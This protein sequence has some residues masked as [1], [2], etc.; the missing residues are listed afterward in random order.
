MEAITDPETLLTRM[1]LISY[2]ATQ[3]LG[4]SGKAAERQLY[5][6]GEAAPMHDRWSRILQSASEAELPALMEEANAELQSWIRRPLVSNAAETLEE[7]CARIVQDGWAIGAEEC[8]RA[9]RCTP[10]LVRRARLAAERHPETGYSLPPR[11]QD[12]MTWAFK[13]DAVG[14]SVRQI[15]TLTGL[16]KS[17]IHDRLS[18][19]RRR[20]IAGG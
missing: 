1:A 14:L 2:G 19:P 15:A 4:R 18:G 10:T 8:A 16:P 7:L 12:P 3:A 17:T 9:M 11:Q 6:P 13:L 5:P 20:A